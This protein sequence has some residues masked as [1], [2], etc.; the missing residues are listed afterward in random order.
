MCAMTRDRMPDE[1]NGTSKKA[2]FRRIA[3]NAELQRTQMWQLI[4]GLHAGRAWFLR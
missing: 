4:G 2:R 1:E 3:A